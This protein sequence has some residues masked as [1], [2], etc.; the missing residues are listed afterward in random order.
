MSRQGVDAGDFGGL[1]R[2]QHGVAQECLTD[3]LTLPAMVHG[4][5]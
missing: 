5:A 3:P 4:Q 1:Q 2:P